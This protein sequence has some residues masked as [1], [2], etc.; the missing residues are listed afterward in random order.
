MTNFFI[1]FFLFLFFFLLTFIHEIHVI[2]KLSNYVHVFAW[3][4]FINENRP[5]RYTFLTEEIL[6]R[7]PVNPF[8]INPKY[9][10]TKRQSCLTVFWSDTN[11]KQKCIR[12][13]CAYIC[14]QSGRTFCHSFRLLIFPG[15]TRLNGHIWF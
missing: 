2:R 12:V 9:M 15:E 10:L 4:W 13:L 14:S 5:T 6:W 1:F 3:I 7:L 8:I 11:K